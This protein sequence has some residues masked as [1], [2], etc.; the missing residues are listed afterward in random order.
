MFSAPSACTMHH[1]HA[2]VQNETTPRTTIPLAN[3]GDSLSQ[4]TFGGSE[5][6]KTSERSFGEVD[7]GLN[8]GA[9]LSGT[10]RTSHVACHTVCLF[11]SNQNVQHTPQGKHG[12]HGC[13]SQLLH[14]RDTQHSLLRTG[15]SGR[16]RPLTFTCCAQYLSLCIKFPQDSTFCY[17]LH[18]IPTG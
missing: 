4:C 1:T 14:F 17:L 9:A 11:S 18:Y 16:G 10:Q 13:S 2:Q 7:H 15:L 3:R 12:R 5:L 8:P 6:L